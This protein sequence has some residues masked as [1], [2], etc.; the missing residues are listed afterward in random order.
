MRSGGGIRPL[1]DFGIERD[2]RSK[3][4]YDGKDIKKWNTPLPFKWMIVFQSKST[5]QR[6]GPLFEEVAKDK[7]SNGFPEIFNHLLPFEEMAKKKYDKGEY[8]W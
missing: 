4:R 8:W 3:K 6:F 1:P 7:M 2:H 5:T